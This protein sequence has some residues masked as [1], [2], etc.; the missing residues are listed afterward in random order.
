MATTDQPAR[1]HAAGSATTREA[2]RFPETFVATPVGWLRV[3]ATS[4]HLLHAATM[5]PRHKAQP[6]Y[7]DDP[8]A[9]RCAE[10]VEIDRVG[11]RLRLWLH[12]QDWT[13]GRGARAVH[14]GWVLPAGAVQVHHDGGPRLGAT[15]GV[16]RRARELVFPALAEWAG[17]PDG[18]ALRLRAGRLAVQAEIRKV[19]G[20]IAVLRAL[21]VRLRQRDAVLARRLDQRPPRPDG[22]VA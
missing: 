7:R 2:L 4:E 6:G 20:E 1:G 17:T 10:Q 21:R 13:G 8:R 5:S 15:V 16:V 18:T 11:Y 9:Q 22:G 3:W 14:R 19:S 12:R